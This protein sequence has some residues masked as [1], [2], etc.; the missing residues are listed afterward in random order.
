MFKRKKLDVEDS[1]NIG[2]KI[3]KNYDCDQDFQITENCIRLSRKSNKTLMAVE[4][5]IY[6]E[7]LTIVVDD[8]E[9]R[10]NFKTIC[11]K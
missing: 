10:D 7:I 9:C 4:D 8:I 2:G 1:I 11:K 6:D 3:E 5:Q